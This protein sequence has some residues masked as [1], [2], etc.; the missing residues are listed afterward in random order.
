M[1]R[2][3]RLKS[4]GGKCGGLL[5][6]AYQEKKLIMCGIAVPAALSRPRLYGVLLVCASVGLI[7]LITLSPFDFSCRDTSLRTGVSDVLLN[8]LLFMPF[9]FGLA[10][11]LSWRRRLAGLTS[12]AVVF[13]GCLTLSYTIEVLQQ[14]MPSRFPAWRNVLAN[15]FGGVLGWSGFQSRVWRG[16]KRLREDGRN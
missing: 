4:P 8:A 6:S 16:R 7:V 11:V 9:G 10:S 14:C 5:G 1:Q 13:G 15:S 12:L 2:Y 3:C